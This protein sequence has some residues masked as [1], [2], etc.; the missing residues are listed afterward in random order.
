MLKT[1]QKHR[2]IWIAVG[3]V[4][5]L[6]LLL[7]FYTYYFAKSSQKVIYQDAQRRIYLTKKGKYKSKNSEDREMWRMVYED[8]KTGNRHFVMANVRKGT[9]EAKVVKRVLNT[10][11]QGKTRT[12]DNVESIGISAFEAKTDVHSNLIDK[13]DFSDFSDFLP[14]EK[15]F[16]IF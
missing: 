8:I 12:F 4:L 3:I 7:W 5:L 15:D 1:F 16:Q 13:K 6:A 14:T 10:F 11:E 9:P 2:K